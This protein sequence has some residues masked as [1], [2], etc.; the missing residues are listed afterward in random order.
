MHI[1]TRATLCV[2]WEWCDQLLQN[3]NERITE[4]KLAR[5]NSMREGMRG[6]RRSVGVT[7]FVFG[8][9][10]NEEACTCEQHAGGYER[11]QA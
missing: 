2:S 9:A 10:G 4:G 3:V 8:D 5:V 6:C 11:L 7:K 1:S